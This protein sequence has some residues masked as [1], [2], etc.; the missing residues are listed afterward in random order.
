MLHCLVCYI[1][2]YRKLEKK[3]RDPQSIKYKIT[4]KL[5]MSTLSSKS[6]QSTIYGAIK[7]GVPANFYFGSIPLR[8]LL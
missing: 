6:E 4:P 1:I 8:S 3:G 2:Y 5:N 7:P